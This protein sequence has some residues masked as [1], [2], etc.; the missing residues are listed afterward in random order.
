[1]HGDDF[2]RRL[3]RQVRDY[4]I[5]SPEDLANYLMDNPRD[6]GRYTDLLE[7]VAA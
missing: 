1:M 3:V 6:A 7:G 5:N 4:A 2:Y